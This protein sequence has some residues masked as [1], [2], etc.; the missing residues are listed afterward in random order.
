MKFGLIKTLIEN[1]LVESFKKDDLTKNMKIFKSKLLT[2]KSFVSMMNIYNN[3]NEHKELD[4]ESANYLIDDLSNEFKSIRLDENTIKFIKTWTSGI[5]VENK[6]SVIDDLLYGDN[7]KPEKKSTA[8]K[9]IVESLGKK[10]I[11]KES[12]TP[13]LPISTM[14]KVANSNA[15]KY[16]DTLTESEKKEVLS[17]MELKDEKLTESFSKLKEDTISKIDKLISE[18]EEGLKKTLSDTREKIQSSIPTKKEYIKL[19]ELNKN[20]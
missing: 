11:I 18:S 2:N 20:I 10:N 6:Y 4:K 3:L 12:K 1:R 17:I 19:L 14:L 9:S 7:T 16:L 13:K 15:K 8:R 5:V